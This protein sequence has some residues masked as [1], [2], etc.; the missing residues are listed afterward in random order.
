MNA[1]YFMDFVTIATG[2][3]ATNFIAPVIALMV[4]GFYLL[5]CGSRNC[6]TVIKARKYSRIF[7]EDQNGIITAMQMVCPRCGAST[8]IRA[9]SAGNC[10][11]CGSQIQAPRMK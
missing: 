9:N 4:P 1:F 10:E 8:R 3:L 11:Y 7:A 2:R 5:W 6:D